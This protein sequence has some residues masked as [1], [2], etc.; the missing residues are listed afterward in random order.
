[1]SNF[2]Q[3]PIIQDVEE[4]KCSCL[5]LLDVSGSMD[6]AP[7]GQLNKGLKVF[8]SQIS[9]DSL[10]CKRVEVGIITFGP[11]K[12]HTSFISARD[13][14][15]PE[16]S[17][18]G[19]TPM[20]Q[21]IS[22][23]ANLIQQRKLLYKSQG[24]AYYKPMVFLITDGGP[25]DEE[26]VWNEATRRVKKDEAEGRYRF[27]PIGVEGAN[28]A[29]LRELGPREPLKLKGLRFDEFF[30]WVARSLSQTSRSQPD[31]TITLENPTA[32]N[33]W[34]EMAP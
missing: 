2:D 7:I 21:A 19:N 18:T 25:T 23:G 11:V 1:M 4:P 15:P 20:G 22:D 10:V 33:G 8:A 17:A 24:I 32:P 16:L 26:N 5:F 34:G 12:E 6:G 27:F 29:R 9:A 13:F 30:A 31:E 14:R 28:F 3:L